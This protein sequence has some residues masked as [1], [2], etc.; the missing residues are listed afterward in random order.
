MTIEFFD[1]ARE[2]FRA[3]VLYYESKQTGLGIRF[4]DEVLHICSL[5]Q[6]EPLLWRERSGGYRRVN[7]PVFPYYLAY[8]IEN[9]IIFIVAV[10]HGHRHPDYWKSRIQG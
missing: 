4:K 8:F 5:I 7:C 10:A 2:E 9:G 6:S 1:V 3:A